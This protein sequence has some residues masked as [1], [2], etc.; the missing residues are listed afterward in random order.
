V[1]TR[2]FNVQSAEVNA[3]ARAEAPVQP[4]QAT[5]IRFRPQPLEAQLGY[6]FLVECWVDDVTN[7]YG[8]DIQIKWDPAAISYVNHTVTI[9][10]ET[11]PNGILHNPFLKVVDTVDETANIP[12]SA[13]GTMYWLE[14]A[15][16][17]PA[18]SFNG[19]GIAFIM[20]FHAVTLG[21]TWI[22]FTSTTLADN[23]G[24]L[25]THS[26]EN[27]PVNVT[28]P[29]PA[30]RFRPQPLEAQLGNDFLVECWVDN[31]TNLYGLCI[32][33]AWDPTAIR[34]SS[35]VVT[36]PVE[37][38]PSGILHEPVCVVNDEVDE[39]AHIPYSSPGTMY[40][41][42]ESS[43]VPAASFNGSGIA[44]IMAFHAVALGDTW[45]NFTHTE[46]ADSD[47][48]WVSHSSENTTVSVRAIHDIAITNVTP[49]KTIIGQGYSAKVNVTV[50][51]QGNY[52]ETFNVSAYANNWTSDTQPSLVGYWKFD[53]GAGITVYDSS[54]HN[55]DGTLNN[56]PTWV[57]GMFGR[58]LRFD[59]VDD[60]VDCGDALSRGFPLGSSP[61]TITA[62]FKVEEWTNM[63]IAGWG[64]TACEG[65]LF[66]I[67]AMGQYGN[68]LYFWGHYPIT[69]PDFSTQPHS[70]TEIELGEWYFGAVTYDGTEIKLY[71]N[72]V[73][74]DSSTAYSVNTQNS[75]FYIG[76]SL[77]TPPYHGPFNGAIDEV[78]IYNRTLNQGEIQASMMQMHLIETKEVTLTSGNFGT[79]TFTWNTSGF[80]KGNYT[81]WA[82]AG[83][84]QGETYTA[85]NTFI[86][87]AI[88]VT[89]PGDVDG[90]F[91]VNIL[92][93]VKITSRYCSRPGDP[94]YAP[95]YDIDNDGHISILDVVICT[96]HYGEKWP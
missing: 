28:N 7:L 34:Y 8:L 41:L 95:V 47:G 18:A 60:Y 55:N 10:V 31:V 24:Y 86:Y 27:A 85:D 59:G 49:Y 25:I 73:L 89:I 57:D 16:L 40:Q 48:W 75:N 79:V 33:I 2:A 69:H 81:I 68:R 35:H 46:L 20:A 29:A 14:A 17:V 36:S 72:G 43:L 71:L 64:T 50:A 3:N 42:C 15:S 74:E 5:A 1:F 58:A 63:A 91:L 65:G 19:S 67:M 90:N 93:V 80:A 22:N 45:I 82:Y 84:V 30:I 94:L 51:N 96:S 32:E 66:Y 83:P 44:F 92:D 77:E 87:G 4:A 78:K 38:Y 23:E 37:T 54:G 62:W 39:T 56:G 76:N 13:Q 61:R 88:A 9:P 52:P 11:Y 53:E 21:D 26:A 70:T 12:D 6:D